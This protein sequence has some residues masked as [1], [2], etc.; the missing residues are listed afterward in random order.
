MDPFSLLSMGIIAMGLGLAYGKRYP[1]AQTL[2]LI[3]LAVFLVCAIAAWDHPYLLS[4]VELE[5]GLNP[6]SSSTGD[7]R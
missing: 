5:L 7:R 4:P 6:S 1:L 2:V 3:D